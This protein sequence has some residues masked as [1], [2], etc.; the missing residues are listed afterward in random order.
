M[1]RATSG[2]EDFGDWHSM[3]GIRPGIL[4]FGDFCDFKETVC[5]DASHPVTGICIRGGLQFGVFC[6]LSVFLR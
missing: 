2:I 3:F 1:T 6:D 4:I 5:G